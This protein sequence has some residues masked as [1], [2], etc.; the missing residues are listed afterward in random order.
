MNK[1]VKKSQSEKGKEIWDRVSRVSKNVPE[2]I[3]SQVSDAAK[4]SSIWIHKH[5]NIK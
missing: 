4:A 5:A 1:V 3:R 2:W